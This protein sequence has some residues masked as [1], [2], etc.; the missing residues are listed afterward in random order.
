LEP[1]RLTLQLKKLI[2]ELC[3]LIVAIVESHKGCSRAIEAQ[4]EPLRFMQEPLG[5]R[6]EP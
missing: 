6:L 2:L 3:R 5:L 4:N 1:W